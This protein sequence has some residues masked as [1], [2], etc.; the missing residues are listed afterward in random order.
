[1]AC[2]SSP[3]DEGPRT[4]LYVELAGCA[5]ELD[6]AARDETVRVRVCELAE[7]ASLVVWVEGTGPVEVIGAS[8]AQR[9]HEG[10]RLLH[11]ARGID[12]TVIVRRG[13][14]EARIARRRHEVPAAIVRARDARARGDL[15]AAAASLDEASPRDERERALVIGMRARLAFSRG[16]DEEC[17]RRYDESIP[18]LRAAGRTSELLDDALARAF[19]LHRRLGRVGEAR[20]SLSA[21]E[22]ELGASNIRRA[23]RS[24]HLGTLLH[25]VGDLRASIAELERAERHAAR[26]DQLVELAGAVE[27]RSD[28]LHRLGRHAEARAAMATLEPHTARMDP[29]TRA[30]F[31]TNLGFQR[32]LEN[33]V[34]SLRAAREPLEEGWRLFGHDCPRPVDAAAAAVNLST[35]ALGLAQLDDAQTWLAR[36][37]ALGVR[38]RTV[39]AWALELEAEVALRRGLYD[40]AVRAFDELAERARASEW[41]DLVWRGE[42]GAGRAHEAAGRS[43]EALDAYRRAELTLDERH[44]RVPLDGAHRFFVGRVGE[45]AQRLVK[46]ALARGDVESAFVAA[47][48]ARR[49]ALA[50]MLRPAPESSAR[51]ATWEPAVEEYWRQREALAARTADTWSVPHE[52]LDAHRRELEASRRALSAALETLYATFPELSAREPE[53]PLSPETIVVVLFPLGDQLAVLAVHGTPPRFLGATTDAS[54]TDVVAIVEPWLSEARAVHVLA[55]ERAHELALHATPRGQS[56][57]GATHD[58]TYGLDLATASSRSRSSEILVV[59]DASRDL[60][61]ARDEA[62][63]VAQAWRALGRE[64][65][66]LEGR[67]ATHGAVVRGIAEADVLHYAGH[68]EA[69]RGFWE[70]GL[71]LAD[72]RLSVSDV[73]ALPSA[74]REAW[75]I[76]CETGRSA[77]VG[78]EI[79]LATAFVAAGA[80][81]VVATTEPVADR[82]ARR[83]LEVAPVGASVEARMRRAYE[84]AGTDLAAFRHFTR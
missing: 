17:I 56:V 30:T 44:R 1:M 70:T 32:L 22:H 59:T 71:P 29:C 13:R 14:A 73:L 60:R 20:R 53:L 33:E 27:I 7:N 31:L 23:A 83:F 67:A 57:L 42:L 75:L 74:P 80:E 3:R 50:S 62:R 82:L 51:P 11:V 9:D 46:L 76:G 37:L 16:D 25:S 28:G 4:P 34:E 55:H 78:T 72:D 84:V 77:E 2:G 63:V 6:E 43:D 21:L 39:E 47:R 19:V 52:A 40:D 8:A 61:G 5:A 68:G 45:S 12:D 41:L 10:G 69:G 79:A 54:A 65:R 26:L 36:A 38:D 15:D 66:S 81:H 24:L 18:L 49:R 35:A 64:V 58:V 48:H